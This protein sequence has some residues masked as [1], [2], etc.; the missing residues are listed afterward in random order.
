MAASLYDH[1]DVAFRK[2][3][4]EQYDTE[5]EPGHFAASTWCWVQRKSS[6]PAT[7][8]PRYPT[9]DCAL[10]KPRGM[11]NVHSHC[12]LIAA[13]AMLLSMSKFIDFAMRHSCPNACITC[14]F[15][16]FAEVYHS[17]SRTDHEVQHALRCFLEASELHFWGPRATKRPYIP[18]NIY[19]PGGPGI[20]FINLFLQHVRHSVAF[21][22]MQ[23]QNFDTLFCTEGKTIS[24][25]SACSYESIS[26]TYD[27]NRCFTGKVSSP[28]AIAEYIEKS[29]QDPGAMATCPSCRNAQSMITTSQLVNLPEYIML[30]PQD[31]GLA[32]VHLHETFML[33]SAEFMAPFT[34]QS[35][36]M[37]NGGH[38]TSLVRG[39]DD[40][41]YWV[42]ND[43]SR[44]LGKT[45][46]E[47]NR[48]HADADVF[49]QMGNPV[50]YVYERHNT[51]PD[52]LDSQ[53]HLTMSDAL[54]QSPVGDHLRDE[55]NFAAIDPDL[56]WKLKVLSSRFDLPQ[57]DLAEVLIRK[58]GSIQA[59]VD[60]L[61]FGNRIDMSLDDVPAAY[62]ADAVRLYTHYP[63]ISICEL[64]DLLK[65]HKFERHLVDEILA[66]RSA[67]RVCLGFT[68]TVGT[69]AQFATRF[70]I[71][72]ARLFEQ[73]QGS[74]TGPSHTIDG[75]MKY[76]VGGKEYHGQ[77]TTVLRPA[78]SIDVLRAT[79]PPMNTGAGDWLPVPS[80]DKFNEKAHDQLPRLNPDPDYWSKYRLMARD[81]IARRPAEE[82]AMSK[83]ALRREA[84]FCAISAE[85]GWHAS[86]SRTVLRTKLPATECRVRRRRD[87]A[88]DVE[89]AMPNPKRR[90]LV[91]EDNITPALSQLTDYTWYDVTRRCGKKEKW[92]V[93]SVQATC[94]KRKTKNSISPTPMEV[95][96]FRTQLTKFLERFYRGYRQ[97]Q[98]RSW[99]TALPITDIDPRW[100]S[101][102]IRPKELLLAAQ[103]LQLVPS[104]D[105][106]RSAL[107]AVSP[108]ARLLSIMS[109]MAMSKRLHYWLIS[110]FA[111][112]KDEITPQVALLD[113]YQ[114]HFPANVLPSKQEIL[115]AVRYVYPRVV[116]VSVRGSGQV[117]LEHLRIR[118]IADGNVSTPPDPWPGAHL[119]AVA[120]KEGL[121]ASE[122]TPR[123]TGASLAMRARARG[124][125][126][127]PLHMDLKTTHP[128][129]VA[130]AA[131]LKSLKNK[132]KPRQTQL[133]LAD[134]ADCFSRLFNS[135][136]EESSPTQNTN[137]PKTPKSDRR[138]IFMDASKSPKIKAEARSANDIDPDNTAAAWAL[139]EV[140][141]LEEAHK[142]GVDLS[143]NSEPWTWLR[144]RGG[145]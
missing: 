135:T 63:W 113:L 132:R 13:V 16:K 15:R 117:M 39:R 126:A 145:Q 31:K 47:V 140:A 129:C 28:T 108:K 120:T 4:A 8:R 84:A 26:G 36:H 73:A 65:K 25:C 64:S 83:L 91:L 44:P 93:Y 143:R 105:P 119:A 14:A 21:D 37:S 50:L 61:A 9:N 68:E 92:L 3:L 19:K 60:A 53:Q 7:G 72:S 22:P 45:W 30:A 5:L 95:L 80:S 1:A 59:T 124:R 97:Q 109:E 103:R 98:A 106:V 46:H 33:S 12:Y 38:A 6:V 34:L 137:R 78:D 48:F 79:P 141:T 17:S 77:L 121:A 139:F 66:K 81:I 123:I 104:I 18:C 130:V 88:E 24:K 10:Q 11:R 55:S 52:L 32:M 49:K 86:Q 111:A 23:T 2:A 128:M 118:K 85:K 99:L 107:M 122:S 94:V 142:Q 112:A 29:L 54:P 51:N 144:L 96:I 56:P 75:T 131:F 100:T 134:L 42:D 102:L 27:Y 125:W 114:L 82:F 127:L 89:S 76:W 138:P 67:D 71:R 41:I 110:C 35:V 40:E 133:D 62:Q 58:G 57:Q 90:V 116:A 74:G 87:E 136:D 43:S 69:D 20:V 70:S 115:A 101:A